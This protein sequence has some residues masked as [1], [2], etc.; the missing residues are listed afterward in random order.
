MGKEQTNG[1]STLLI[2]SLESRLAYKD[3]GRKTWDRLVEEIIAREGSVIAL[4]GAGSVNGID[5]AVAGRLVESEIIPRLKELIS[6]GEKVTILFDGDADNPS[7]PDIGFIAGRILDQFGKDQVDLVVVT[8]QKESWYNP[9]TPNAN[10]ANAHAVQAVT[11]VFPEGEYPGD[12]NSFTQDVQL[13]ASPRY[14]QWYIGASG[15]I[16]SEQLVDFN[17]KVPANETREVILFRASNNAV[18]DEELQAKLVLAQAAS[19]DIKVTK[20]LA[21]LEQRQNVYGVHWDNNGFPTIDSNKFPNLNLTFV[22]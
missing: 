10:L 1:E 12:H 9:S 14:Q 21:Q 20:L 13:V 5:P 15:N 8:A 4:R 16:A 18:L 11:Y 7:K 17:A 6:A 3:D 19:D 22:T 2:T